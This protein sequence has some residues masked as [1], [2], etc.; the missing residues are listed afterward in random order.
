MKETGGDVRKVK[1]Q[2]KCYGGSRTFALL[3]RSGTDRQ[4]NKGGE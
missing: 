3:P 1:V 2:G 4:E